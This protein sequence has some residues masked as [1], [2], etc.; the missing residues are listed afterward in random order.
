MLAGVKSSAENPGVLEPDMRH[1]EK[2]LL[3]RGIVL[4]ML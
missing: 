2:T 3:A 4:R 1:Q